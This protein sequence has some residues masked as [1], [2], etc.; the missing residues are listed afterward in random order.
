M[1]GI[2]SRRLT[3]L[4]TTPI[5]QHDWE[6]AEE[7]NSRLVQ[8]ILAEEAKGPGTSY[9]NVGGWHSTADFEKW[10]GTAGQA[11][12]QRIGQQI[13]HATASLFRLYRGGQPILWRITLWANVNR[14]GDYNRTHIHPGAAWSGVYYVDAGDSPPHGKPDSGLLVLHH[15]NIAAA[16]A[17]FGDV[18]PSVHPIRPRTGMSVVFPAHLAHE[19]RPYLGD[20]PRISIA[21]NAKIEPNPEPP[22]RKAKR[23]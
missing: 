12:I 6:D 16:A 15:P 9:S 7:L 1:A 13:N 2:E 21:F 5:L 17:F 8:L 22:A 14:R 4:F 18:T 20:R 10:S 3:H 23:P 19:V 11:L